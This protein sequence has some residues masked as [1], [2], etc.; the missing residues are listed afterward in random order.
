MILQRGMHACRQAG[1]SRSIACE[2]IEFLNPLRNETTT[3]LLPDGS[4]H[5]VPGLIAKM[6]LQLGASRRERFDD[7]EQDAEQQLHDALAVE[8]RRRELDREISL[9]A[10]LL[11]FAGATVGFLMGG[12]PGALLGSTVAE[13]AGD[14]VAERSNRIWRKLRSIGLRRTRRASDH[15]RPSSVDANRPWKGS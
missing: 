6:S 9:I 1:D 12:P 14:I 13:I 11:R 10:R 15:H 4:H 5:D 8:D 2:E 3:I 7:D